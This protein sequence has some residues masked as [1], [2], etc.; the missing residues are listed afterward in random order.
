M[1]IRL[2]YRSSALLA[3]YI[4]IILQL[5]LNAALNCVMR[6]TVERSPVKVKFGGYTMILEVLHVVPGYS[7]IWMDDFTPLLMHPLNTGVWVIILSNTLGTAFN[8]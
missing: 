6:R 2:R 5:K 8:T 7:C 1:P 3:V 4:Y